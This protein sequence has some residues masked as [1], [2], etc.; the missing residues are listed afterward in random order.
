MFWFHAYI[1]LCNFTV[2]SSSVFMIHSCL[3]CKG[4]KNQIYLRGNVE[5]IY[6]ILSM[7]NTVSACSSILHLHGKIQKTIYKRLQ[8]L[9][10]SQ[11]F[12]VLCFSMKQSGSPHKLFR[13]LFLFFIFFLKEVFDT[14]PPLCPFI[15][16]NRLNSA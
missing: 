4:N 12:F 14:A 7:N 13:T 2:H 6:L 5:A 10:A 1:L 16:E 11:C 9:D 3:K 8:I 15:L